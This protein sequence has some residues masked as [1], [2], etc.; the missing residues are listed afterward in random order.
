MQL[1]LA[2]IAI[3]TIVVIIVGNH[4]FNNQNFSNE[5][6]T[7]E[8]KTEKKPS[9]EHE[10]R[11]IEVFKNNDAIK[12][13]VPSKKD[14]NRYIGFTYERIIREDSYLDTWVQYKTGIYN[15]V[16]AAYNT[17]FMV[18]SGESDNEGVLRIDGESDFIGG[19]HGYDIMES[20]EMIIDGE[21]VDLS[22]N[23]KHEA[24]KI[25]IVNQSRVLHDQ[26]IDSPENKAFSR[27]KK[28][29]WT[30]DNMTL[31]GKWKAEDVT[32]VGSSK[33][34]DFS[35]NKENNSVEVIKYGENNLLGEK[36]DVSKDF[37]GSELEKQRNGI[38][39]Q[40]LWGDKSSFKVT[41]STDWEMDKYPN[42]F[43]YI[44]DFGDRAKI[45]FDLTGKHTFGK[46]ESIEYTNIYDFE[47]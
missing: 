41:L 17:E 12:I 2:V 43:G 16:G 36:I 40:S 31:E 14:E 9:E 28:H 25:E 10:K 18:S 11:L 33:L 38:T 23:F 19:L 47:F 22:E 29:V 44:E 15:K 37:K 21:K 35:V 26:T 8:V 20:L 42:S 32:T 34:S 6:Q 46:G 30:L 27:Y 45:Y 39:E 3:L 7:K 24:K 4:R 13:F 5:V 1:L